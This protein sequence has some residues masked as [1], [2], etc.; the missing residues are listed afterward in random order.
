MFWGNLRIVLC[1][2]HQNW[3][4]TYVVLEL[5]PAPGW[6]ANTASQMKWDGRD[7]LEVAH[8]EKKTQNNN[9]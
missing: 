5:R 8:Y 7:C 1:W 2:N 9:L 4:L 3:K 6:F